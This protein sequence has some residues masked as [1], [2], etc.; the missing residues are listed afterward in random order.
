MDLGSTYGAALVGLVV[1]A[2][3]FGVTLIQT[4]EYYKH[5][6]EDS[7][8]MKTLVAILTVLDTLHLILCARTLYWY[9]ITNFDNRAA[10]NVITWTMAI[11]TDCNGIIGVAVQIFFARRVWKMSRNWFI[12]SLIVILGSIHFGLGVVFTAE[13]FILGEFSKFDSLTAS[14]VPTLPTLRI[15][16]A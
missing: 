5:Y 7:M 16:T 3:I 15:L 14:F 11:Q 13:S 2:T 9:L 6:G 1:E 10:L 8:A 12:T 4:Y